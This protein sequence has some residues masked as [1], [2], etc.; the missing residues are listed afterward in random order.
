MAF[1][2]RRCVRV[3][4]IPPSV[5]LIVDELFFFFSLASI[6]G[7]RRGRWFGLDR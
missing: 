6:D 4:R 3:M 1:A 2:A 7:A 5:M